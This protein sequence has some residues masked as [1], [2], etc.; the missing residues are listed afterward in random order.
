M[1]KLIDFFK[2]VLRHKVVLIG[3]P[4]VLAGLVLVLTTN[5]KYDYY[6]E[7][8]LYTGLASGSSVEME[9]SF[10]YFATNIAFDNL[11]NIVN[12]R[13][14]QEEVAIRLLSQH[15][16]LDSYN[17]RYI[18]EDSYQKLMETVPDEIFQMVVR[19]GSD[20]SK[21]TTTDDDQLAALFP[22]T[23]S[24]SDYEQTVAKLSEYMR[25][26]NTNFVYELLN[27]EDE[28]YSIK[29]ISEIKAV[30]MSNSDLV[31]ISYQMDDPGICQQTL[32]IF[33]EVCQRRYQDI[34][35]NSS[36]AVVK[37]FE[38]QL[39]M[40]E[41]KLKQAENTLLEF[42][43][44]NNIINYYEQSKAVAI[45]K[46]EMEVDYNKKKA[47]LAG[48]LAATQTIEE[49]I[50]IQDRVQAKSQAVLDKKRRLGDLNFEVAMVESSTL[51]QEAKS[52]RLTALKEEAS[53]LDQEIRTGVNELYSYQN[54]IEGVPLKKTLPDWMDN[55]V[56]SEDLK[57]ELDAMDDR[58]EE[59]QRRYADYAPAGA[60]LKRIER[61]I[62]VAEE[63]YLDILHGLNLAKLKSQDNELSS[64][65][66]TFD[67]P[68]FPLSPIPTKRKL[69][70]IASVFVGFIVVL[71][72]ILVMEYF[73]N[74]LK[75]LKNA[76]KKIQ[77]P[78]L[79][80]IPKIRLNPG[81]VDQTIVLQRLM[82]IIMQKLKRACH[83][84]GM[85]VSTKTI[86]MISTQARE[87]KTVMGKNMGLF[88]A[89]QGKRVLVLNYEQHRSSPKQNSRVSLT[90]KLL[91][92][93]DPR[94]D[95]QHEF[96]QVDEQSWG[97]V[98]TATYTLNDSFNAVSSYTDIL[99]QNKISSDFAPHYVIVELPGLLNHTYP[100]DLVAQADLS[101]LVCRSNRLW[102][103]AD[104]TLID[105]L[106]TLTNDRLQFVLNG[107]ELEEIEAV[108]GDLPKDR[109]QVRSR[110]KN[111][112]RFQF[113][114]GNRI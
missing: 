55:T 3:T 16:L 19:E 97:I 91:G 83:E 13:E 113:Y 60:N 37:Y 12:S 2:L 99:K 42:N 1:M 47:A 11:I 27:Y 31:K 28:H 104:K 69:L 81:Q 20:S 94:V 82:Q 73:D 38:E 21:V 52:A 101:V 102:S 57:A 49:K 59:F 68:Y 84:Q 93:P 98:D 17:P 88:L 41:D 35:E 106:K 107:V 14:T 103:E 87:G 48:A 110:L 76:S 45:V 85:E 78:A 108:L 56:K 22:S 8:M 114:A 86:L 71:A 34:K 79:G 62:A 80:V 23:I 112:L 18:S 26:S 74:T 29:A 25:S 66:K 96:L 44:D 46:E 72:V 89:N 36:D 67:P 54:S 32:A 6:S 70:L 109:S 90:H 92:Y 100:M 65:L 5:P 40:A 24:R 64:N 43:K 51:D 4:I 50:A 39:R 53:R 9:K 58:N 111:M 61:E 7:T 75:N 33:S 10:N 30:R 15:L 77:L 63:G 105:N 95:Q